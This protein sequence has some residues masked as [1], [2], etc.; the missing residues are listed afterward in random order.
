MDSAVENSV[1]TVTEL[2]H[3][4]KGILESRFAFLQ[5]KGEVSN[6]KIQASGHIYF[7]LK[8]SGSQ[9]SA[10]LFRGNAARLSRPPKSGD[11]IVVKGEIS[12]YAPRGNY[13]IIVR[14]VEYEGVGTLLMK[15][16]E[17]K[18]RLQKKGWFDPKHKKALPPYPKTIGV[19]T[20]PTGAV[21]QD[22]LNVLK[23]RS[24]NFHLIL[25]PVRVQGKGAAEEIA[26]AIE[27]FNEHQMVDLLIVGRGG[28]SLEDLWEF[29]E[30]RVAE[31]IFHSKIPVI[32]AVGHETDYSIADFVADVRAPTPSAA[33]E[34]SAKTLTSQLDFLAQSKRQITKHLVQTLKHH[35]SLIEGIKKHPLIASPF[36]LLSERSQKVDDLCDAI[37]QKMRTRLGEKKLRIQGF[38]RHLEGQKPLSRI[39]EH[40]DKLK[41]LSA[42]MQ[43]TWTIYQKQNK[44]RLERLVSH[45][46]SIDP[47]NLLQKGY[48]IPFSEKEGSVMMSSHS[49][50]KGERL[51]ILFSDGKVKTI[52]EEVIPKN[53]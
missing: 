38:R 31:A 21:I 43:T 2:T 20:S 49:L 23:R 25:N 1:L 8:D 16:H 10:V 52:V 9:I 37:D 4:I 50:A 30:E 42:S 39:L 33:A 27:V 41:F 36:Y 53:E 35:R 45:L 19:V 6:L 7:T 34:I 3:S 24:Q 15:L 46:H 18:D 47:K 28:G 13:Q 5:V 44:E 29:N 51:S 12:V 48:C 26:R 11:Q 32:S 17:L 22:I 40:R 14:E